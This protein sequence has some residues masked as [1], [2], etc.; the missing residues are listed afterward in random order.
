MVPWWLVWTI[1]GGVVLLSA[2]L[3]VVPAIGV[4]R[5]MAEFHR[6]RALVQERTT[7]R[8]QKLMVG[9]EQVQARLGGVQ[10]RTAVMQRKVGALRASQARGRVGLEA[11]EEE[12]STDEARR[13]GGGARR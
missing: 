10:D 1:V 7:T 9:W 3:V 8:T 12:T 6:V 4:R 2:L 11:A 5:R 13:S